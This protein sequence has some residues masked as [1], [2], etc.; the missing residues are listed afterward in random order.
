MYCT[1]LADDRM[2][3]SISSRVRYGPLLDQRQIVS[4]NLRKLGD[5]IQ[6]LIPPP[7]A[8]CRFSSGRLDLVPVVLAVAR[9]RPN[10]N[11]IRRATA[12]YPL[13][14]VQASY[15]TT[16]RFDQSPLPSCLYQSLCTLLITRQSVNEYTSITIGQT[17][18][19][20]V[21]YNKPST[22]T[23]NPFALARPPNRYRCR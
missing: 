5:G 19:H 2:R 18:N 23:P 1:V 7:V 3:S 17:H 6:P 14:P 16:V 8:H 20:D 9:C 22:T 21:L 11:A 12:P 13:P 10:A 15:Q 4:E